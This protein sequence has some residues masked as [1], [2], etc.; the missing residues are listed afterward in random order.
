M[1]SII[2]TSTVGGGQFSLTGPIGNTGPTGESGNSGLI[3]ITYGPTGSTGIYIKEITKSTSQYTP[4]AFLFSMSDGT[5][6]GPI[7]GFT[8]PGITYFNSKGLS[9]TI[10]SDYVSIFSSVTGGKTFE[11]RGL[12]GDNQYTFTNLSADGKEAVLQITGIPSTSVVYGNT[13]NNFIAITTTAYTATATDIQ[14]LN[15]ISEDSTSYFSNTSNFAELEFGLTANSRINQV[16]KV[17]VFTDFTTPFLTVSPLGR[18]FNPQ[19]I[20]VSDGIKSVDSG[21]YVLDLDK[22]SVFKINTPVGI[23]AFSC[24]PSVNTLKSWLFF[25]EGTDVWNLPSNVIF[26]PGITGIE[27][28]AFSPGMNI[29]RIENDPDSSFYYASFVDRFFGT[30]GVVNYGG[31]GS[32]CKSDGS[33]QEYTTKEQCEQILQGTFTALTSCTDTCL[34]GSCCIGGTCYDRVSRSLCNTLSGSWNTSNC[35]GRVCS[36]NYS[37]NT[38][39]PTTTSTILNYDNTATPTNKSQIAIFTAKTDDTN[40]IIDFNNSITDPPTSLVMKNF[41]IRDVSGT[42]DTNGRYVITAPTPTEGITFAVLWDN[43]SD[44]IHAEHTYGTAPLTFTLKDS[45]GVA[46]TSLQYITQPQVISTC[47][48]AGNSRQIKIDYIASRYCRDCYYYDPTGQKIN[49]EVQQQQGSFDFCVDLNK[50]QSG[51]NLTPLCTVTSP[52]LDTNDCK[53][54]DANTDSLTPDVARTCNHKEYGFLTTNC[55]GGCT[56]I[57]VDTFGGGEYGCK[58]VS[59]SNQTRYPYSTQVNIE[60]SSKLSKDLYNAG[61]TLN[62][63]I[64]EISKNIINYIRTSINPDNGLRVL[65]NQQNQNKGI[66]FIANT[67]FASCCPAP[68]TPENDVLLDFNDATHDVRYFVIF[69]TSR[70]SEFCSGSGGLPTNPSGGPTGVVSCTS[71]VEKSVTYAIIVKTY[72]TRG[73]TQIDTSRQNCLIDII[74]TLTLNEG[75]VQHTGSGQGVECAPSK[76]TFSKDNNFNIGFISEIKNTDTSAIAGTNKRKLIINRVL[77]HNS[78]TPCQNQLDAWEL[79]I[80]CTNAWYQTLQQFLNI[81]YQLY[82]L[83]WY[84]L[85]CQ[86]CT[87]SGLIKC[88]SNDCYTVCIGESGGLDQIVTVRGSNIQCVNSRSY[89]SSARSFRKIILT[90]T[91]NGTDTIITP[92]IYDGLGIEQTGEYFYYLLGHKDPV[93]QSVLNNCNY[94]DIK[95]AISGTPITVSNSNTSDGNGIIDNEFIV[96]YTNGRNENFYNSNFINTS[97]N[98]RSLI[99]RS[100]PITIVEKYI[101]TTTTLPSINFDVGE[102]KGTS[103]RNSLFT[104]DIK[105]KCS[106]MD[107]ISSCI[108]TV[109]NGLYFI[110]GTK[111]VIEGFT[112][113]AWY[114]YDGFVYNLSSDY[115]PWFDDAQ[116]GLQNASGSVF[117]AKS[118]TNNS[119]Y[120]GAGIGHFYV[121]LVLN[122]TNQDTGYTRLVEKTKIFSVPNVLRVRLTGSTTRRE[123]KYKLVAD[124][125]GATQCVLMDCSVTSDCSGL[126]DC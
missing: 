33:C 21:G 73:A 59:L 126:P 37:L 2:G 40:A 57:A 67:T 29:L 50:T 3:G 47:G 30:N 66:T 105:T 82:Q 89:G 109:Y 19:V 78:Q 117:D 61:I 53:I 76:C 120:N 32:C 74:K 94:F 83:F 112:V 38:E 68:T 28:Y 34:V 79:Q 88:D 110:S 122:L 96:Y 17:K 16:N 71:S 123:N 8:G 18:N 46:K 54:T 121:T 86:D 11:F 42:L 25:I 69:I 26:E 31:V 91:V 100:A 113:M 48:G 80:K 60:N 55:D 103:H 12:C 114:E 22:T 45:S 95:K 13:A 14:V 41:Y 115:Q 87:T 58:G 23:T 24:K 77:Y 116:I 1:P 108:D 75:C 102:I 39:T 56:G 35:D 72:F 7:F 62:T 27:N 15:Q 70:Y 52:V 107:N 65:F 92:K 101:P 5:I 51:Y 104:I 85:M 98:C 9:A 90:K 6:I 63:D 106:S 118:W 125:T 44:N 81:Y 36:F 124:D 97:V 93:T 4:D 20:P 99:T 10:N 119:Q 49:Y 111:W 43:T 84:P 64:D